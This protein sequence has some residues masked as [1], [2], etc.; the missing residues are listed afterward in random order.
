[1]R[2]DDAAVRQPRS[3]SGTFAIV[4]VTGIVDSI[5]V[6]ASVGGHSWRRLLERHD[7]TVG[8]SITQR[9]GHVVNHTGAGIVATFSDPSTGLESAVNFV[10][11]MAELNLPV[12][13]GVHA[14]VVEAGDD[15]GVGGVPV[16]IAAHVQ[17]H[18][19]PSEILVS[20]TVQ[21]LLLGSR[22]RF[23]DRGAHALEGLDSSWRL[24]AV[25]A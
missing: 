17:S 13:A 5:A 1:V 4:L 18:A 24:Y 14:G 22:F 6:Q 25:V 15:G 11:A 12:R 23:A 9:G 19:A 10:A 21:D 8:E 20:R 3:G 16:V 7:Q 2:S